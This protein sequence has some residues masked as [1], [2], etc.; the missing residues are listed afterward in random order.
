MKKRTRLSK[1]FILPPVILAAL[2]IWLLASQNSN[3]RSASDILKESVEILPV[4]NDMA[5]HGEDKA[6]QK[7]KE[8]SKMKLK[9]DDGDTEVS[10]SDNN[11]GHGGDEDGKVSL[12]FAGDI[13]LSPEHVLNAYDRAG[14]ITGILDQP[15][16]DEIASADLFMANEEF[17][18]SERGVAAQDKQYTFRIPPARLS[19]MQ[20]I[21]PDIV[22]LANNHILDYGTDAM[23]DT[24]ALLDGA[25]IRRVGAGADLTEAKKLEV[26]DAGGKKIGFLAASRVIPVASWTAGKSHP[27]VL[28]T[29]DPAILLTE[30]EAAQEK[31][32]YLVVYIHWGIERNTKPEEYQRTL[33]RQYI[34][35]GADLVVGSHPHVLQGIEYYRGKPILYSLGNFIFGSSI[36]RTMLARVEL[37][38]ENRAVLSVIPATSS[39]GYTRRIEAENRAEFY[40]NLS[41]LSFGI[42]IDGNGTI[43]PDTLPSP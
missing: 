6:G 26:M 21:G 12:L 8:E 43:H 17:P 31:C 22:A 27:G 15:L 30:I 1:I 24:C 20:E 36:P 5:R 34:D 2:F 18:F 32:D 33:A 16:R 28:T 4:E 29:Y 11:T 37:D 40:D 35:A 41:E 7:G 14:G 39:A 9:M 25:G 10:G 23:L 19:V 3:N 42:T 13:Y 38:E